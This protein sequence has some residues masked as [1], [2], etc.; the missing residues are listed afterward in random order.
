MSPGASSENAWGGEQEPS[1]DVDG[2]GAAS[3]NEWPAEALVVLRGGGINQSSHRAR[4]LQKGTNA[5]AKAIGKIGPIDQNLSALNSFGKWPYDACTTLKQPC[6][7]VDDRIKPEEE[8][9]QWPAHL[10]KQLGIKGCPPAPKEARVVSGQIEDP[11]LNR[12]P[13]EACETLGIQ[14][15]KKCASTAVWSFAEEDNK[16]EEVKGWSDWGRK[17]LEDAMA[18]RPI[19]PRPD[20]LETTKSEPNMWPPDLKEALKRAQRSEPWKAEEEKEDQSWSF[21]LSP[22]QHLVDEIAEK[23][24]SLYNSASALNQLPKELAMCDKRL[25]RS[26]DTCSRILD[27]GYVLHGKV[28]DSIPSAISAIEHL[29]KIAPKQADELLSL[30]S[31][32]ALLLEPDFGNPDTTALYDENRTAVTDAIAN[33]KNKLNICNAVLKSM[34][35]YKDRKDKDEEG[36]TKTVRFA[37]KELETKGA[38]KET[39]SK[40]EE[41]INKRLFGTIVKD[42]LGFISTG[43]K[44]NENDCR[45]VFEWANTASN[46]R[47]TTIE[48]L[49]KIDKTIK[50]S[51][52]TQNQI[53]RELDT[54]EALINT[55]ITRC[56]NKI[57]KTCTSINRVRDNYNII[58]KNNI[59]LEQ[60]QQ[61]KTLAEM[62]PKLSDT[63]THCSQ[64]KDQADKDIVVILENL[65]ALRPELNKLQTQANEAIRFLR[66]L[67][68]LISKNRNDNCQK[69]GVKSEPEKEAEDK[70][71][72]EVKDEAEPEKEV[73]DEVKA[74]V[75]DAIVNISKDALQNGEMCTLNMLKRL[76]FNKKEKFEA[77]ES[78]KTVG[79]QVIDAA[80]TRVLYHL[81]VNDDKVSY[82]PPGAMACTYLSPI[83][84]EIKIP[85]LKYVLTAVS[86]DTAENSSLTQWHWLGAILDIEAKTI[87][88]YNSLLLNGEAWAPYEQ[89]L[90]RRIATEAAKVWP[91]KWQATRKLFAGW[92]TQGANINACGVMALFA[93]NAAIIALRQ[94]PHKLQNALPPQEYNDAQTRAEFAMMAF[95]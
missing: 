23:A 34:G 61:C 84:Q 89:A 63:L 5:V 52:Y 21:G 70:V 40:K 20:S 58:W 49:N 56:K 27:V 86:V 77:K 25:W 14:K 16:A 13:P 71:K 4:I 22:V 53:N 35:V 75:K 93:M 32:L 54:L 94:P 95:P 28:V 9:N 18:G 82:L 73:N 43:K 24:S 66:T 3:Q 80:V 50:I 12:W 90:I 67:F 38:T 36:A 74:E 17:A 85:N 48:T 83:L 46:F 92:D 39:T 87:F 57:V 15:K 72:A 33:M 19:D 76:A 55:L 64:L 69:T 42:C 91:G 65:P 26:N 60:P 1:E 51:E 10:C 81:T 44:N 47:L 68:K 7:E 6:P 59:L 30:L 31:K 37:E 78:L 79:K 45:K 8:E 62:L 2:G 29:S 11:K 88:I 41:A